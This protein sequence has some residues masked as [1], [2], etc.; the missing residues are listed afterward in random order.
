MSK[1]S[2]LNKRGGKSKVLSFNTEAK[3]TEGVKNVTEIK[4]A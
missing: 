1:I 3:N 4:H 2:I